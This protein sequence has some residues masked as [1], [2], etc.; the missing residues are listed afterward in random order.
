MV[1]VN[2]GIALCGGDREAPGQRSVM[3]TFFGGEDK[4][5]EK[6]P[7]SSTICFQLPGVCKVDYVSI[8]N[9]EKTPRKTAYVENGRQ[10]FV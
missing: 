2:E 6:S 8:C 10:F 3:V 4:I 5:Y 9:L 1:V 7:F